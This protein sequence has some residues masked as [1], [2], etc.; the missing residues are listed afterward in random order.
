[1]LTELL[2]FYLFLNDQGVATLGVTQNQQT[3]P[4]WALQCIRTMTAFQKRFFSQ[5]AFKK[6]EGHEKNVIISDNNLDVRFWFKGKSFHLLC[7]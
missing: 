7:Y 1:M 3:A 2:E 4:S 5:L 6:D